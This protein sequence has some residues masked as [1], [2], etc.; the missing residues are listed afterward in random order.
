M[1]IPV[2]IDAAKQALTR[3]MMLNGNTLPEHTQNHV[4]EAMAEPSPVDMLVR[5]MEAL[6]AAKGDLNPAGLT[7]VGQ[8]AGFIV[9]NGWHGINQD[10]RGT[11][12]V[13]AMRRELGEPAP[14]GTEWAEAETDPEPQARYGEPAQAP[15]PAP[16]T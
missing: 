8:L 7:I 15:A 5:S 9:P 4:I 2:S 14:E 12:I 16:V 3:Y 11:R 13:R 10:N 6:Y 1:E